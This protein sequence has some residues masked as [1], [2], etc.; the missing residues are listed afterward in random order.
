MLTIRLD[1]FSLEHREA[2][3]LT[4]NCYFEAQKV[5]GPMRLAPPRTELKTERL[6]LV[7]WSEEYFEE[8]REIFENPEVYPCQLIDP[9]GDWHTR[10]RFE[11]TTAAAESPGYFA[12]AIHDPIAQEL[13]GELTFHVTDWLYRSGTVGF[14]LSPK[15][16]GHGYMT[17]ALN[18]ATRFLHRDCGFLR[19]DAGTFAD[20]SRA[21]R[22]LEKSGF[23]KTGKTPLFCLRNGKWKTGLLFASVHPEK[24]DSKLSGRD[25]P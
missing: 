16:W 4:V 15:F 19:I 17:E 7:N 5:L 1:S 13:M 6:E 18:E 10:A 11:E 21:I 22:S 14:S 8:F 9:M 24:A 23:L 20:N 3:A 12:W 25:L 2:V